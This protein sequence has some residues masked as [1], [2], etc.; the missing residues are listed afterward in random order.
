MIKIAICDDDIKIIEKLKAELIKYQISYDL[1]FLVDT[2]H[3]GE[4][5]INSFKLDT[6]DLLFLDIYMKEIDG[7][8]VLNNIKLLNL[9]LLVCFMSS[10]DSRIRELFS[11]NVI[12]FIDKPICNDKLLGLFTDFYN[13]Y[14]RKNSKSFVFKKNS[15]IFQILYDDIIMIE[16]VQ[17][18]VIVHT[19]NE[20]LEFR[21]KISDIW[22]Q[23][24]NEVEFAMPSRSYIVNLKYVTY[25]KSS[26]IIDDTIISIGRKY[27]EETLKKYLAYIELIGFKL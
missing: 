15:K 20:K 18:K 27:K 26:I 10:D 21:S 3:S 11:A 24:T 12:G 7:I 6:Y 16:S 23:L 2:Y 9:N 4:E 19:A 1:E 25:S 13:I 17:H 22:E 14:K 5:L 8:E